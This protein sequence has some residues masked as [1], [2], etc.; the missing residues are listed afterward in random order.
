MI[1]KLKS[2]SD[3]IGY[4]YTIILISFLSM[5]IALPFFLATKSDIL[6]NLIF[7]FI[8]AIRINKFELFI[9]L[10]EYSLNIYFLPSIWKLFLPLLIILILWITIFILSIRKINKNEFRK[11][12]TSKDGLKI[13]FGTLFCI[14]TISVVHFFLNFFLPINEDYFIWTNLLYIPFLIISLIFFFFG[15]FHFFKKRKNLES[16][17]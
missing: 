13:I 1:L 11:D 2:K 16:Q 12:I 15:I 5:Y 3:I 10:Y 4:C 14:I 8:E 9:I 7:I 17:V 6:I